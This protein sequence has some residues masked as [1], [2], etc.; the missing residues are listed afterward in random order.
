MKPTEFVITDD[1]MKSFREFAVK[2]YKNNPD[3]GLTTA[4]IDANMAW[5]K[6]QLRSEILT[7]A[8]GSDR[9]QQGI[10]DYDVQL[11]KAIAE[12]PSAADLAQRS[13]KRNA[14][15]NRGN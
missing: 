6:K 10:S 3:F 5:C 15:N 11:Q 9:A 13:W 1:I 8:Y 14:A 2:Y 7:A 12:M 4:Q